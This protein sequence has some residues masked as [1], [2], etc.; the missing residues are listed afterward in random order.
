M[1]SRLDGSARDFQDPRLPARIKANLELWGVA[2]SLLEI[3]VTETAMMQAPEAAVQVCNELKEM[4][5]SVA[6]DDFGVGQS[7]LVYLDRLDVD[8]I[9]LD[10]AF[11]VNIDKSETSRSIVE[12]II[13]LGTKMGKKVIAEGVE[14]G[15]EFRVLRELGCHQGQGYFWG[16]PMPEAKF[17]QLLQDG[18]TVG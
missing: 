1:K 14:T 2:P 17:R 10:Q 5:L 6:I 11:V 8:I 16:R 7:P 3:E 13:G 4:G 12:A 15:E 18:L 9:K